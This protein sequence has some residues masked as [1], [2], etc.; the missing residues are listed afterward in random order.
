MASPLARVKFPLV[1]ICQ[2]KLNSGSYLGVG[3]RLLHWLIPAIRRRWERRHTGSDTPILLVSQSYSW[4]EITLVVLGDS[5]RAMADFIVELREM[6]FIDLEPPGVAGRETSELAAFRRVAEERLT[7]AVIAA[8]PEFA[9]LDASQSHVFEGSATTYGF[10]LDLFEAL[11]NRDAEATERYLSAIRADDEVLPICKWFIKAGHLQAARSFFEP[12]NGAAV[13]GCF[14][15]GDVICPAPRPMQTRE[16]IRTLVRLR[17]GIGGQRHILGSFTTIA[18]PMPTE[19]PTI[20]PDKHFYIRSAVARRLLVPVSDIRQLDQ[21]LTRCG[22]PKT[23]AERVENMFSNFNDC[24]MDPSLFGYFLEL[25]PLMTWMLALARQWSSSPSTSGVEERSNRLSAAVSA[26]ETAF[27]NRY[28]SSSGMSEITDF[29][30]E[31]KGTLHQPIS[32]F[33]AAFKAV[34]EAVSNS[35]GRSHVFSVIGGAPW[36]STTEDSL[37]MNYLHLC[38]PE[39][40]A[41]YVGHEVGYYELLYGG[42]GDLGTPSTEELDKFIMGEQERPVGRQDSVFHVLTIPELFAYVAAD[43]VAFELIYF[44]DPDLFAFWY[45][46]HWYTLPG[47]HTN[48]AEVDETSFAA[49]MLRIS[50]VIEISGRSTDAT[51]PWRECDGPLRDLFT[52]WVGPAGRYAKT[53]WKVEAFAEWARAARDHARAKLLGVV[54]GSWSSEHADAL[55]RELVDRGLD[56]ARTL[57]AGCLLPYDTLNGVRSERCASLHTV[58][59]LHAYLRWIKDKCGAGNVFLQRDA[60]DGHV[61]VRDGDAPLLFDSRGGTFTHSPVMRREYFECRAALILSLVDMS[62]VEKRRWLVEF[63]RTGQLPSSQ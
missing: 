1:S 25:R 29:N 56:Y 20:A 39:F 34:V 59:L 61:I 7:A 49:M 8:V 54:G 13:V 43:L 28:Y 53:L 6:R 42:R 22:I 55:Y 45:L 36:V 38:Q 18:E 12:A 26:F 40:F 57:S 23:V 14:G 35:D 17:Q 3:S 52:K 21:D 62:A 33:D 11:S 4:H 32:A 60:R 41:S 46:A 24:I 16:F 9:D 50:S 31:F 30:L 19:L 10:C 15:K 47:S 27:K 5:F 2:L 63:L 44:G 51:P 58:T 37:S 48:V